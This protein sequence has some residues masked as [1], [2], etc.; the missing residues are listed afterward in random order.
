MHYL[1][2]NNHLIDDNYIKENKWINI[3]LNDD[4]EGKVI[5][6]DENREFHCYEEYDTTIIEILPEIDGI[7]DFL[8]LDEELCDDQIENY[9]KKKSVYIIHYPKIKKA[10]VS[11][12]VVGDILDYNI[13]H[14]CQIE[15]TS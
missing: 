8:K 15:P 4:S 7:T 6:I 11:F 1:I 2:T 14:F 5:I 3:T 13:M 12:S 9:Y 10:L